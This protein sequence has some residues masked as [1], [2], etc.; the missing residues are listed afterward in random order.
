MRP[1]PSQPSLEQQFRLWA[2]TSVS[3]T[4]LSF[5]AL[6][7]WWLWSDPT[8]V[9]DPWRRVVIPALVNVAVGAVLLAVIAWDAGRRARQIGDGLRTLREY[10]ASWDRGQPPVSN[11]VSQLPDIDEIAGQ[12]A[13][14]LRRREQDR[15]QLEFAQQQTQA[16]LKEADDYILCHQP[17]LE[18]TVAQHRR[19]QQVPD[20]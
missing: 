10:I 12:L 4:V 7:I 20:G 11:A 8:A 3:V 14:I 15:Q 19:V 13:A 18:G 9:A 6:Q 5:T 2:I 17:R 1:T 16:R